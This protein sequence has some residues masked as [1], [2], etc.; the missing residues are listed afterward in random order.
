MNFRE[1]I[2]KEATETLL[3]FDC[4]T[5]NVAMR[6]GKTL[7]GLKIASNFKK[8]LVSYPIETIKKGW[9]SDAQE[10]GFDIS[11]VIFTTHLSLSKHDLSQFDCIILDELHDVSINNW[12]YIA[13]ST[14]K[15]LY[16]LTATPPNRGEKKSYMN[17]YCPIRYTKSM[18]ETTGITNKDYEI[19]VHLLEPSDKRDIKLKSGKFWSEKAQIDFYESKYQSTKNF[20]MMLM[21]IRAIQNS[22][23]KFEYLKQLT[24]QIENKCIKCNCSLIGR[25]LLSKY[26]FDCK[27]EIKKVWRNE[28]HKRNINTAKNYFQKNKTEINNKTRLLEA[29]RRE[30]VTDR[31][32][33]K[34]LREKNGFTIEQLKNN[35][36]LLEIK[37]LIIKTKRICKTS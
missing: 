30:N 31:Y 26:C 3:K 37:R 18:D 27:V 8:V 22:K 12:N 14:Y 23:T 11:H 19:I 34:L 17:M 7:I 35:P 25:Q 15:K 1:Q 13:L 29:N 20:S 21:L 36:S 24:K 28:N 4:G 10:F 2:Q 9:I 16:G 32:V 6:L 33:S 5:A